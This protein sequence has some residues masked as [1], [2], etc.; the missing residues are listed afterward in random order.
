MVGIRGNRNGINLTKN[1][2]FIFK[3]RLVISSSRLKC[4]VSFAY[5]FEKV[6]NWPKFQSSL[7]EKNIFFTLWESWAPRNWLEYYNA[8]SC[9][10]HV[11]VAL[12]A[13]WL[14][15]AFSSSRMNSCSCKF[16][17]INSLYGRR[18]VLIYSS[19]QPS[20]TLLLIMLNG[21][22]WSHSHFDVLKRYM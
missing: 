7:S 12:L 11:T 10:C 2:M 5:L 19:T 1:L 18:C 16:W 17:W 15:H 6:E 3:A 22:N 14:R 8:W 4:Y 21:E 9:C 13:F 20:I